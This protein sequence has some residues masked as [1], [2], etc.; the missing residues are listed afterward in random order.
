MID[1]GAVVN[2]DNFVRL[3]VTKQ[4]DFLL[5]AVINGLFTSADNH[6]R[7]DAQSSQLSDRGLRRLC[8]VLSRSFGLRHQRD[9][10]RAK[11]FTTH[12]EL[13]LAKGFDERHSLDVTDR[14]SQLD[15]AHFGL[16]I[17]VAISY[18]AQWD[19]FESLTQLTQSI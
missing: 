4:G 17:R 6:V 8:F 12:T 2:V 7:A 5:D 18:N 16:F 14:A 9:V 3:D 19:V 11:V 15:D 10:D 1:G 13:E